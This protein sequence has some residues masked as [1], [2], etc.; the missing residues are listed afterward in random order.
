MQLKAGFPPK[1]VCGADSDPVVELGITTGSALTVLELKTSPTPTP[2][3]APAASCPSPPSAATTA[4]ATAVALSSSGS[5]GGGAAP[6]APPQLQ[7]QQQ[8]RQRPDPAMV[9]SLADMGFPEDYAARVLE[10]AGGD[11]HTALEMCMSGDPA[12]L[13]GDVRPAGEKYILLFFCLRSHVEG[14][15]YR[16]RHS[17]ET[18]TAVAKDR[19]LSRPLSHR[20]RPPPGASWM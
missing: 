14:V 17:V 4:T 5:G 13:L 1:D 11:F 6:P 2:P 10:V 12:A 8:Q 9:R 16:W 15:V 19:R 18:F 3:P 7:Q 20:H